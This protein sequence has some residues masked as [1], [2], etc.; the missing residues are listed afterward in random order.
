MSPLSRIKLRVS[1]GKGVG[2]NPENRVKSSHRIEPTIEPKHVLVEVGLQMFWLDTAMMR[3][4]DPSFQVAENEMDDGQV[5]LSFV[6]VLYFPFA[7]MKNAVFLCLFR[8]SPEIFQYFR[9]SRGHLFSYSCA[10]GVFRPQ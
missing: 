10:I 7:R 6:G 5:R 3:P 1:R 4:L 9:R 8:D 2:G